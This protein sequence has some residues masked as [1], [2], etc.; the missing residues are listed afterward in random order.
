MV[1]AE[2]LV[3][4]GRWEG[5]TAYLATPGAHPDW[6][7]SRPDGEAR[8]G[9]DP[10]SWLEAALA[11]LLWQVDEMEAGRGRPESRGGSRPMQSVPPGPPRAALVAA[12]A[13]VRAACARGLHGETVEPMTAINVR[14]QPDGSTAC[15][16]N[17]LRGWHRMALRDRPDRPLRRRRRPGPRPRGPGGRA[18]R[19]RRPVR[20]GRAALDTE[21][22]RSLLVGGL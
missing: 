11:D 12:M 4:T 18:G 21:A 3:L 9:S 5:E 7:A 17:G 1:R 20:L 13:A 10:G 16:A 6:R 15:W 19:P 14:Q 2:F 22:R 8:G